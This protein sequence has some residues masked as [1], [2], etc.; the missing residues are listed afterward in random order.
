MEFLKKQIQILDYLLQEKSLK[1]NLM[2][3]QLQKKIQMQ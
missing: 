3:K 1:K 2:K